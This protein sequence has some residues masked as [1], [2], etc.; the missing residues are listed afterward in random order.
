LVVFEITD[1]IPAVIVVLFITGL[2]ILAYKY[3]K[4]KARVYRVPRHGY[5]SPDLGQLI[6]KAKYAVKATS[7]EHVYDSLLERLNHGYRLIE[8]MGEKQG[9]TMRFI[10]EL[11]PPTTVSSRKLSDVDKYL[12]R[13][14]EVRSG[15]PI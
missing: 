10:R 15:I 11:G 1:L 2:M 9:N 13:L 7:A 8:W 3:G 12:I 4:G 5:R 14:T 6:V